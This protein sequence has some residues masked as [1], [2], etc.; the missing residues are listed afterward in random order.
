MLDKPYRQPSKKGGKYFEGV[1]KKSPNPLTPEQEKIRYRLWEKWI[2]QGK[3]PTLGRWNMAAAC[4]RVVTAFPR[5]HAW[6]LR[7]RGFKGHAAARRKYADPV[8][9]KF[10]WACGKADPVEC[11]RRGGQKTKHLREQ[12]KREEQ[13]IPLKHYIPE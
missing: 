11:G 3:K 2:G 9:G 10:P 12:K 6:Y 13:G 5:D 7:M 1:P 8:T 4:A